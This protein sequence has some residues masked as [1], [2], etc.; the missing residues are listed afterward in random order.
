MREE[1]DDADDERDQQRGEHQLDRPAAHDAVAG[2]DVAR[3]PLRELEAL[4]ERAQQLLGSPAH[5]R[6]PHRRRGGRAV[7]ERVGRPLAGRRQRDRRDAARDER[8]LL[9]EGERE[10][11]VDELGAE[12]GTARAPAGLLEHALR[13]R[14]DERR[15]RRARRVAGDHDPRRAGAGDRGQVDRRDDVERQVPGEP[16]CAEAAERAAVGREKDDRVRGAHPLGRGCIRLG[17]AACELDERRRPRGVVVRSRA[18]SDVVPVRHHDDR[19]GRLAA[20]DGPDVLEPHASEPGNPRR[21]RVR[22]NRK[23]VRP[24][25]RRGTTAATQRAGGARRRSAFVAKSSRARVSPARRSS[26][27]GAAPA[28]ASDA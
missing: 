2:P 5:R 27:A 26:A 28:A 12:G 13:G 4:V 21:P 10:G 7:G 20:R 8:P 16:R 15:R 19:V 11:E 9:V 1:V 23:A 6:E 14:L 25:L 3:R 24:H 18:D 22:G 17:I